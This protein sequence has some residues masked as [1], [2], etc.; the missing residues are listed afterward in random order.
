MRV[1]VDTNVVAY[2]VLGTEPFA[3]EARSFWHAVADKTAPS[4]W[5]AELANTV[6]IAV[7]SGA[8]SAQ[9]G[10]TRLDLAAG[11]GID[12]VPNRLLLHGALARSVNSGV[13]ICDT[14]FVELA[15]RER[16]PLATF[17]KNLLRSFMGIARRPAEL[18]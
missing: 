14:L 1:V 15:D 3:Q 18:T 4:Q 13:A 12:S 5:E 2:L 9:E 17:D 16:L 7:R 6:W 8:L 11:L 10:L